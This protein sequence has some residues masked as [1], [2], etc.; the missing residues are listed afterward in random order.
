MCDVTLAT[1]RNIFLSKSVRYIVPFLG[2]IEVL[3]WLMAI[4]QIMRNLNNPVCFITYALGYSTG[5]FFGIKIEER[6]ALGLQV[7]RIITQQDAGELRKSLVEHSFGITTIDAEGA[8]GPV[9]ILL[10][11]IKRKDV[12][13]V[14]ALVHQHQPNAFY[15][16]ED[17]RT[18]SKGVFP[19]SEGDRMSQLRRIFPFGGGK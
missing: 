13:L 7:M 11:V 9:K 5:I 15:S 2:F 14:R 17:I 19:Q 3:I 10:T 18:V 4:S 16:V 1:L 12:D 8:K 6:L